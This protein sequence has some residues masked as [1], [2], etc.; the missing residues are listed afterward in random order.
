MRAIPHADVGRLVFPA[1]QVVEQD[2]PL[3]VPN[4]GRSQAALGNCVDDTCLSSA[5]MEPLP[6]DFEMRPGR[7]IIIG[8]APDRRVSDVGLSTR[9]GATRLDQAGWGRSGEQAGVAR[10]PGLRALVSWIRPAG[11]TQKSWRGG[12]WSCCVHQP[13]V[14][15]NF[16]LLPPLSHQRPAS[17]AWGLPTLVC[18]PHHLPGALACAPTRRF[19]FL[20]FFLGRLR[21]SCTGASVCLVPRCSNLARAASREPRP[22]LAWP[23][24]SSA[25]KTPPTGHWTEPS[26]P[27]PHVFLNLDPALQSTP[28]AA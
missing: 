10:D 21:I 20:I 5:G 3:G 26:R 22:G 2:C 11:P 25:L 19:L 1:N 17:V 28:I 23:K 15:A 24:L 12:L 8:T 7:S 18:G 6:V 14:R 16:L 13:A 27:R 4:C 9:P